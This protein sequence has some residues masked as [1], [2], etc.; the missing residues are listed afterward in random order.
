MYKLLGDAVNTALE[1]KPLVANANHCEVVIAPVYTA[2][3]TVADGG[4]PPENTSANGQFFDTGV[5]LCTD[6]P[7]DTVTAAPQESAQY[8]IDNAWG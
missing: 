2:I 4:A 8:C 5:T 3:K 6:D 1:L 7:Q